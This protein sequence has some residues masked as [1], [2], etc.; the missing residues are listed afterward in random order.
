MQISTIENAGEL[1]IRL[2]SITGIPKQKM[3]LLQG[4]LNYSNHRG[5]DRKINDTG[6]YD[7]EDA[8]DVG[9]I[10]VENEHPTF[11]LEQIFVK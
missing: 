8:Q 6:K 5:S 9:S 11:I 1:K 3:R 4:F 2:E 10:I 7:L